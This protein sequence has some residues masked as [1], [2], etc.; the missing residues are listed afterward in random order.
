M[1]YN[2]RLAGNR[3]LVLTDS[4]I[5]RYWM[6][7]DDPMVMKALYEMDKKENWVLVKNPAITY[8]LKNMAD[9]PKDEENVDNEQIVANLEDLIMILAYMNTSWVFRILKWF[10]EYRNMVLF[11]LVLKSQLMARR[12]DDYG[13]VSPGQLMLDRFL[14]LKNL[15]LVGSIFDLER[16]RLIERFINGIDKDE[17]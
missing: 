12:E 8:E 3:K 10:E 1:E 6:N 2:E 16:G 13:F 5:R 11:Q 7:N 9:N 17:Y 15:S 14:M 4:M